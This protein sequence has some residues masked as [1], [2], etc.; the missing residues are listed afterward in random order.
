[1][2]RE[3]RRRS[4]LAAAR[5]VFSDKGYHA[6]KVEDIV[7][8]AGIARGTFYLYFTDKRA[9]FEELLDSFTV[10]IYDAVKVVDPREGPPSV[11]DQLAANV[12]RVLDLALAERGLVKLLL[13][14]AVGLDPT[15]DAKLL[16]FY[17]ELATQ[18][19]RSLARGQAMRLVRPCDARMLAL[20]LLGA[21]KELI[22]RTAVAGYDVD[23]QR[24]IDE[25]LRFSLGGVLAEPYARHTA[26]A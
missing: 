23:R 2:D 1:M 16:A 10:R 17:D 3:A 11:F 25:L 26:V 19:E 4:I 13:T 20:A 22:Y 6:A 5:D 18:I 24:L 12:G 14:H 8:R 7:S 15:L 9:I 21:M